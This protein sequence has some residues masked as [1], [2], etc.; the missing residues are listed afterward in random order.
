MKDQEILSCLR[1]GENRKAI[2]SLYSFFPAIKKF[3]VQAGAPKSIVEDIFQEALVVLFQKSREKEFQLTSSLNTYLIAVAKYKFY[4]FVRKQQLTIQIDDSEFKPFEE[5]DV[6]ETLLKL[7]E[8]KVGELGERCK[9]VLVSFYY[10]KMSMVQIADAL[11]FSSPKIAKNQKYKCL[12]RLRND[13]KQEV[14]IL[15]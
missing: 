4:E 11:G 6:N 5:D 15:S 8:K 3:L 14:N 9:E 12:E 7:I 10:K 2:R 1:S 13:V